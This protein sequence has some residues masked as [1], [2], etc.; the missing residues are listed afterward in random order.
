MKDPAEDEIEALRK[1]YCSRGFAI[2]MWERF[3]AL[4]RQSQAENDR[5]REEIEALKANV[6]DLA[7][8]VRKKEATDGNPAEI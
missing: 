4:L 5:L 1:E 2:E 3:E 8:H 6:A 7:A